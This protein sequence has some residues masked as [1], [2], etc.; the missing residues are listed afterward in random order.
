MLGITTG[1]GNK[2]VTAAPR[3]FSD[4]CSTALVRRDKL[5]QSYLWK[6]SERLLEIFIFYTVLCVSCSPQTAG[7]NYYSGAGCNAD[8]CQEVI[9]FFGYIHMQMCSPED[10]SQSICRNGFICEAFLEVN[11]LFF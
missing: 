4:R 6:L 5:C 2:G 1:H 10:K 3:P 11:L 8:V 9:V 7:D